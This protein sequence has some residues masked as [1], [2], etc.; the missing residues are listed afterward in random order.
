[1]RPLK[2]TTVALTLW[3]TVIFWS[4]GSVLGSG[5]KPLI[6]IADDF[7]EISMPAPADPGEFLRV[8]DTS[9]GWDMMRYPVLT[10]AKK[11]GQI[12]L[13]DTKYQVRTLE[14]L[15]RQELAA[16]ELIRCIGM[17]FGIDPSIAAKALAIL[18][19]QGEVHGRA[20]TP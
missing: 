10:R 5:E 13:Q 14:S 17:E 18:R 19:K 8:W 1:M 15:T 16:E 11:E 2:K 3:F 7:P 20:P 12:Y 4:H 6:G 9:F